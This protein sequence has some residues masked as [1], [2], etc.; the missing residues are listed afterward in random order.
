[1]ETDPATAET[2][3]DEDVPNEAE[4]ETVPPPEADF[5]VDGAAEALEENEGVTA[6]VGVTLIVIEFELV[7]ELVNELLCELELENEPELVLLNVPVFE[8]VKDFDEDNEVD[9]LVDVDGIVAQ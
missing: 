3:T 2:E 8:A 9:M 4:V 6:D 5:E 7:N 1:L